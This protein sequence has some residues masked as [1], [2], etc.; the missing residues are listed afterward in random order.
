MPVLFSTYVDKV[1]ISSLSSQAV[2]PVNNKLK[3]SWNKKFKF[4][5][6]TL[7]LIMPSYLLIFRK[8]KSI[9]CTIKAVGKT[10][11]KL[12]TQRKVIYYIHEL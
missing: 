11:L 9:T 8:F 12:Y 5:N 2:V 7:Y 6:Q 3:T 10:H 1:F 4:R